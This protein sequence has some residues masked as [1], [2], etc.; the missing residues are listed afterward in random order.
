V[1]DLGLAGHAQHGRPLAPLAERDPTGSV[2]ATT[3][4]HAFRVACSRRSRRTARAICRSDTSRGP[5]AGTST[6]PSPSRW[7]ITSSSDVAFRSTMA[8]KRGLFRISAGTLSSSMSATALRIVP[9]GLRS[10]WRR[11]RYSWLSL[12]T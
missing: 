2:S 3:T 8:R 7:P 4:S 12:A 10:S 11:S 5:N 6:A 1:P 9:S